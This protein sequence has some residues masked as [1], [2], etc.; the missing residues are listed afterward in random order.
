MRRDAAGIHDE[1]ENI[2]AFDGGG[3]FVHHLAAKRGIGGVQA[4]R[5]YEHDLAALLRDDTL[6][7]ISRGLRFGCDDGDLL[8]DQVVQQRGIARADR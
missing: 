8:S 3:D 1:Q 4:W 2:D 5:I 7:A 6:N